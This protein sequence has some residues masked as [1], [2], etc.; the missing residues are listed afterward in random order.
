MLL[1]PAPPAPDATRTLMKELVKTILLSPLCRMSAA[2]HLPSVSLGNAEGGAR[3]EKF[4]D[5]PTVSPS[6]ARATGQCLFSNE[7]FESAGDGDESCMSRGHQRRRNLQWV[8][9]ETPEILSHE[10]II[11]QQAFLNTA[12]MFFGVI[13][14]FLLYH[15]YV[16]F[17]A[18]RILPQHSASFSYCTAST[19]VHSQPQHLL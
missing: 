17:Q 18:R 12:F 15:V 9:K 8:M 2:Q 5:V 3:S 13:V 1:E 10:A 16:L 11:N 6:E 19:S 4:T 7:E 14:A